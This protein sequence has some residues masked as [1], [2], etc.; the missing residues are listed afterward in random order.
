MNLPVSR[1]LQRGVAAALL[2]VA[3][4]AVYAP[5]LGGAFV[6]DDHR[7]Y[8]RNAAIASP[9]NVVAFFTDPSTVDPAGNWEGIYRPL[10]SLSFAV[11]RWFFATNPVGPRLHALLLHIATA[12][13]IAVLLGGL[14]GR[15]LLGLVLALAWAVHPVHVESVAWITS[16]ADLLGGLFAVL[17]LLAFRRRDRTGP[18]LGYPLFV[19]ALFA[20]ESSVVV[21][22]LGALL[23]LALPRREPERPVALLKRWAPLLLL[24]IAF[25][26]L[27]QE[28]LD[29]H[30]GQRPFW[31]GSW[32]IT[33][34]SMVVGLGWYV[35]RLAL[36]F[37]PRFDYQLPLA[38]EVGLV[39]VIG[40]GLALAVAVGLATRAL[41][42]GRAR[43]VGAG[44]WWILLALAPVSNLLVPINILV[45]ERFLYLAAVGWMLILA[46]LWSVGWRGRPAWRAV[47]VV[48]AIHWIG[49]LGLGTL[50]LSA[51]WSSETRLWSTVLAHS[52]HHFRA[53]HGIARAR[54]AAGDR[55]GA[56][57]A[58]ERAIE[59][60]GGAY[61]EPYFD[62]GRIWLLEEQ[63]SR[64]VPL[65]R[66]AVEL[67]REEGRGSAKNLAYMRT[68]AL[69]A[70]AYGH[71][72]KPAE[73]ARM[74]RWLAEAG[75]SAR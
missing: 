62:L 30:A 60:G 7:F 43:A 75:S 8:S 41:V 4:V 51:Q 31:G 74:N 71:E 25:V 56:R 69:L 38:P 24:A 16:R 29:G 65:L 28:V 47:M 34:D 40:V 23:D 5:S 54:I 35:L 15:R 27:R 55:A 52:P 64:A 61:P 68:L 70:E 19:A 33:A 72:G 57:E 37:G 21:P 45:A 26:L 32:L 10:R 11:D 49:Y 59:Y 12:L 6:Y 3:V 17:T 1:N 67:W 42:R 53:H 73:A 2:V 66:R 44:V 13:A 14:L 48:V 9:A 36:P 39:V 58:L 20:K 22:L 46:A 50:A 63:P 18:V